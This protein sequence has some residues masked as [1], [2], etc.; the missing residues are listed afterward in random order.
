MIAQFLVILLL[1]RGLGYA[2]KITARSDLL[3]VSTTTWHRT[4]T[5]PNLTTTAQKEN[6]NTRKT[7]L[8]NNSNKNTKTPTT[9]LH[10]LRQTTT[11]TATTT[12][13]HGNKKASRPSSVFVWVVPSPTGR[14]VW[15]F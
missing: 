5:M 8:N 6:K 3:N 13:D 9:A 4:V 12:Q 11:A 10:K 15:L 14:Y 1:C 2:M 7:I